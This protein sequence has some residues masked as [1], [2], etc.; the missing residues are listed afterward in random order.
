MNPVDTLAGALELRPGPA[1]PN[2]RSTRPALVRAL[3]Q[4][5]PAATV[6]DLLGRVFALCG[7]AHR[8]V[9][10]RAIAA[11]QGD[12]AAPTLDDRRQLQ[13]DTL[14]E[15]LRRIWLDWPAALSGHD[16]TAQDLATLRECPLL[17]RDAPAG[18]VLRATRNWLATQALAMPAP[19]WL[20]GW[21]ADLQGW[22]SQWSARAET[23]PARLLNVCRARATLLGDAP[24]ALHVHADTASLRDLAD[25]L[26]ADSGFAAAPTASP[27]WCE[28]GPWTRGA[29]A[30]ADRHANAWLRLGA[31]LADAVCLA[32]DDDA[33]AHQGAHWLQQG[34]LMLKAGEGL[35][36]CEMARGLLVHRVRLAAPGHAGPVQGRRADTEATTRIAEYDVV[37]PTEWNFH[38]DGPVAQALRRL[39]PDAAPAQVRLL[40]A[41]FDPCVEV[42]VVGSAET[43]R[44]PPHA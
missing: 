5:K 2:I 17:H 27:G 3:V 33:A 6:P 19:D 18:D 14:R 13:L 43:H 4:G 39:P 15:Q 35:A 31:R 10:R 38:V 36:W 32:L 23:L 30:G 37:A 1:R 16:P 26:R 8:L 20:H 44:E 41:A 29:D 25:R 40:A 42:R 34:A 22:L 9:A 7:G 11:A 24:H 21:R 28:T 12:D